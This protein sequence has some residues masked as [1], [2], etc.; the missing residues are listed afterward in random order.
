MH[1]FR[2]LCMISPVD[3]NNE[4]HVHAWAQ[5]LRA[6]LVPWYATFGHTRVKTLVAYLPHMRDLVVL[7][8]VYAN[9][10]VLAR[11]LHTQVNLLACPNRL[12][13]LASGLGYASMVRYLHSLGHN[14]CDVGAMNLAARFGF[15]EIVIFLDSN[16]AEG[17]NVRA[18]NG[19]AKYGHLHVVQWLH[20]HRN[21]GC[22]DDAMA[23]AAERGHLEVVEW[24]HGNCK[25]TNNIPMAFLA[26]IR[27]NQVETAKYLS[28]Q[29]DDLFPLTN[30]VVEFTAYHGHLEILQWLHGS[31]HVVQFTA[32]TVVQA[33]LGGHLEVVRW[34]CDDLELPCPHDLVRVA[35]KGN[36]VDILQ[37]LY[38][39]DPRLANGM[40]V[41]V[42]PLAA[43]RGQMQLLEWFRHHGF[44]MDRSRLA[45]LEPQEPEQTRAASPCCSRTAREQASRIGLKDRE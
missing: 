37:Y 40:L 10:L 4:E 44:K 7:D 21:E 39:K 15:L 25:P 26:A 19:A 42:V 28:M 1:P 17:C 9:D 38:N 5:S 11:H 27:A 2:H 45:Q 8:A 6:V 32:R 29:F 24:L 34:L 30:S 23:G 22:S 41:D 43:A 31:R 20:H 3:T 35:A 16:R 12:L 14:G 18:M 33:T 36:R 13:N